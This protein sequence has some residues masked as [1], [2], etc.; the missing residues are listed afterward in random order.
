M[1]DVAVTDDG[2]AIRGC[3]NWKYLEAK[4]DFLRKTRAGKAHRVCSF[5]P[6]FRAK[7]ISGRVAGKDYRFTLRFPDVVY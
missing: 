3:S 2:I 1:L 4:M 6:S 7:M 5:C